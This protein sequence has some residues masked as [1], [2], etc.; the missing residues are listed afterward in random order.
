MELEKYFT[1]ISDDQKKLKYICEK[2][3]IDVDVQAGFP[4]W[5][6]AT[7]FPDGVEVTWCNR[8]ADRVMSGLGRDMLP[9]YCQQEGRKT[10]DWTSPATMFDNAVLEDK[11][12][13]R[14]VREVTIEQA[15]NFANKGVPIIVISREGYGHVAIVDPYST[16]IC[17]VYN[18]G[19]RAVFGNKTIDEAFYKWGVKPKFFL[20][21]RK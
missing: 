6:G 3:L 5:D 8:Y 7:H 16:D 19:S 15:V 4:K 18:A 20:V 14:K 12:N 2:H 9:L 1:S 11:K 13:N 10:I 17:R 21:A